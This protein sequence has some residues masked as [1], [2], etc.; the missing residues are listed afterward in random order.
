MT[1]PSIT[2][3]CQAVCVTVTGSEDDS[4]EDVADIAE[5]LSETAVQRLD[6]ANHNMMEMEENGSQERNGA[7]GRSFG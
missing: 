3:D 7:Q 4:L 5:R 1:N 6:D 2:M